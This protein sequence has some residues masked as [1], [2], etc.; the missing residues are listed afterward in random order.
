MIGNKKEEI[1]ISGMGDKFAVPVDDGDRAMVNTFNMVAAGDV[2]KNRL[3]LD[4]LSRDEVDLP[5]VDSALYGKQGN[6]PSLETSTGPRS[7]L[8]G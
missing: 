1:R 4:A 7:R 6:M 2:G 3:H 8:R 5:I